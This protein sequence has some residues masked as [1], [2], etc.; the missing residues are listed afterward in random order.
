MEMPTLLLLPRSF[1]PVRYPITLKSLSHP[2]SHATTT[3]V[4]RHRIPKHSVRPSRCVVWMI[5]TKYCLDGFAGATKIFLAAFNMQYSGKRAGGAAY[6]NLNPDM[7]SY[8][9]LNNQV[10][11]T[12]QYGNCSCAASGCGEIDI[13]EVLTPGYDKAKSCVHL[14]GNGKPLGGGPSNYIPRPATKAMTVAVIFLDGVVHI[15][16]LDDSIAFD[17][18]IKG[19]D[20]QGWIKQSNPS[21]FDVAAGS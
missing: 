9:F 3:A 2:T 19:T 16:I 20:V 21:V 15:A 12:G 5:N 11:L 4:P 8:W 13:V 17:A 14:Q 18:V 1:L 6:T 10:L 7:P